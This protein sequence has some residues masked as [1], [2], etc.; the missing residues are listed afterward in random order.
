MS[1]WKGLFAGMVALKI[2]NA[3]KRPTVVAPKGFTV[4]GLDHSG[5]GK[6]WKV[7]YIKD[8]RPNVKHVFSIGQSTRSATVFG[9]QFHVHWPR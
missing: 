1:F 6:N 3:T 2:H 8:E 9:H 5:I 4:V 7:Y